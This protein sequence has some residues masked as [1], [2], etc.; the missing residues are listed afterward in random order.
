MGEKWSWTL[1]F[2]GC[3]KNRVQ[4]I[5]GLCFLAALSSSRTTVVGPSVRPS[6]GPSV[7]PLMFVKK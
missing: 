7:G 6:V 3:E 1:V 5:L 4:K 2:S